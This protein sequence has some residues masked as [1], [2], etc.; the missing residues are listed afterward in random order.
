MRIDLRQYIADAQMHSVLRNAE[1][2]RET[3]ERA[4]DQ[5]RVVRLG[6]RWK[7]CRNR[8]RAHSGGHCRMKR[9]VGMKGMQLAFEPMRPVSQPPR[10][11]QEYGR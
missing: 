11:L 7:P 6:I 2:V 1:A 10:R 4:A 5:A 9:R 3:I 8:R